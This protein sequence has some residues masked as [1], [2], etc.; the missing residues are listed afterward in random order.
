M[1][2]IKYPTNLTVLVAKSKKRFW[3]SPLE[4]WRRLETTRKYSIE[5][6]VENK[7]Q[8]SFQLPPPPMFWWVFWLVVC[9]RFFQD[10]GRPAGGIWTPTSVFPKNP[11]NARIM[12]VNLIGRYKWGCTVFQVQLFFLLSLKL[13]RRLC[14]VWPWTLKVFWGGKT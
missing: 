1:L 11:G 9:Q 10:R 13:M 4:V 14:R 5:L 8:H 3:N 2:Y 6:Y 12:C 7:T